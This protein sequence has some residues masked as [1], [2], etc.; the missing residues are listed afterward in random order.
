[1]DNT[2]N[3]QFFRCVDCKKAISFNNDFDCFGCGFML[4]DRWVF[5]LTQGRRFHHG[6]FT[7][8]EKS[9]T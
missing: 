4:D 8:Q 9:K 7:L 1:M 3:E 5:D 6:C 2:G